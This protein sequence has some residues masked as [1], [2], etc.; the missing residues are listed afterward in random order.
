MPFPSSALKL[1]PVALSWVTPF[2]LN[3]NVIQYTQQDR[4]IWYYAAT[5]APVTLGAGLSSTALF[6][7]YNP[8]TSVSNLIIRSVQISASADVAAAAA[9][10]YVK[11]TNGAANPTGVTT[12]A[13]GA[14]AGPIITQGGQ[15]F[16]AVSVGVPF[17][18]ATL[19]ST[20]LIIRIASDA[21]TTTAPQTTLDDYING[22]MGLSPGDQWTI[23]ASAAIA[24][25][26]SIVWEEQPQW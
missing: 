17:I 11:V 15:N 16:G 20:P 23:Q 13:N 1:P 4:A 10:F 26:A 2:D 5:Q 7:L 21:L 25:Y 8:T 14:G 3:R 6:G 18:A 22:Q 19:N 24:I 9:I 12:I